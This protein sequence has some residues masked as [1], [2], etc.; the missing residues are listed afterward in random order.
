MMNES[1]APFRD[2]LSREE[3]VEFPLKQFEGDIVIVETP[4]MAKIAYDYLHQFPVI[5]FDTETKP[6]F[7]K[8]DFHPVALLQLAT[9]ERAFLIRVQKVGIPNE[10]RMLLTNA[11]IEKPGVA[12]RV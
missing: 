11:S 10:I 5:G 8:G 4:S 2:S 9:E 12:I 6:T 3:L 1:D 7:K